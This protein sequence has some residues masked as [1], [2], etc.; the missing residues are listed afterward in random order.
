[1]IKKLFIENFR[2]IESQEIELGRFNLLTGANNSGKSSVIYALLALKNIV[3]NSNQSLDGFLNL[4]FINLGGFAQSVYFKDEHRRILL[5]VGVET[6][7]VYSEYRALLGK[8][9]SALRISTERPQKVALDLEVTFPYAANSSTGTD[10]TTKEGKVSVTWNGI[11]AN[12]T[13]E[14]STPD[15]LQALQRLSET[16]SLAFSG[17]PEKLRTLDFVPLRRGFMKPNY[18]SVPLQPQLLNDDELAT[19]LATDRDLEG[20]VAFY[21]EKILERTFTVRPTLG[22]ANFSLQSRDRSTGFVCDLVNE[23]FGTNQLVT[24]LAKSL[25]REVSTVCIEETEIHLHPELMD[26][27]VSVLL[28][29]AYDEDKRFIITT[30]SEHI[31]SSALTHA[32]QRKIDPQDLKLL[33]VRKEGRE[34]VVEDQRINESGQVEGG[35]RAFYQTGLKDVRDFFLAKDE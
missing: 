17:P 24:I 19:L 33:Y 31:V 28:Q 32:F 7:N 23:G 6:K 2:G 1:M 21:L 9:E 5:G 22:T 20:K 14:P 25:R 13:S 3:L 16:L 35:L 29:I 26:R 27:F 34:T 15:D 4:G 30:H 18:S 11:T 8:K 12:L 10:I